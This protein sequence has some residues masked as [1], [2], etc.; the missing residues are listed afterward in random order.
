MQMALMAN[1]SLELPE[2]TG[3]QFHSDVSVLEKFFVAARSPL[4][5]FNKAV[6]EAPMENWSKKALDTFLSE[7]EWLSVARDNAAKLQAQKYREI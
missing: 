6:M 3:E 4:V 7:T 5:W 1:G 2:R